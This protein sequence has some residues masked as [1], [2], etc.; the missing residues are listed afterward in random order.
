MADSERLDDEDEGL[1]AFALTV[2]AYAGST[3]PERPEWI[4]IDGERVA[5]TAID[6]TWREEDR[7]GF[8]VQ[9]DSGARML[10]YYVPELDL[11]SGVAVDAHAP[12]RVV[13]RRKA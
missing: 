10:V 1:R 7:I 2:G 3:S 13:P 9:L 4:E 11:W 5:V 8:R 6:A 12:A